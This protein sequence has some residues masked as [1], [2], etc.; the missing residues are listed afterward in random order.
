MTVK[1][2]SDQVFNAI[3]KIAAVSSR[4]E[5]DALVK[6]FLQFEEF[7]RVCVYAYDPLV[8]YGI[9]N[10]PEKAPAPPEGLSVFSDGAWT[11]L[12]QLARRELTGNDARN[13]VKFWIDVMTPASAELFRRILKKDLRAGFTDGTVNRAVPG[14]IRQFAYM[15][16]SLTK[17]VKLAEWPWATG[18]IVQEKADGMFVNVDHD[19]GGMIAISTRAGNPL[20]I[21]ELGNLPAQIRRTLRPGTQT[22]GELLV[23]GPDGKVMSREVGNGILNSV[24]KGGKLDAGCQVMLQAWDQIPQEFAKPKGKYEC[25]Y[26]LRL[27]GLLKQ[28]K[29]AGSGIIQLVPTKMVH[30]FQEALEFYR[31]RLVEGK[32][33]A[34]MKRPDGIWKD[35]TSREQVKL[36]LEVVVDLKPIAFEPGNGKFKDLFGAITCET[37]DGLLRVSVSGMTDKVR[38]EMHEKRDDVLKSILAVKANSIMFASEEGKQHSLFLPRYVEL[39]A[40]KTEADSLQRVKDQFEAAVRA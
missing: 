31:E 30:S 16:C 17:D 40:D 4:T 27:T 26:T 35:G 5:K 8:T 1:M 19:E 39:R 37:S 12:D 15:R 10:V 36:K 18:V 20:P 23:I 3:E 22:H 7:K 29:N 25:S 13:K 28:I 14:T 21:D 11:I 6:Q 38:K 33:G 24:A 9:E 2:S 32:E 34:V